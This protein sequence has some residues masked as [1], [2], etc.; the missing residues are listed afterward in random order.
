EKNIWVNLILFFFQAEDGIRDFHVTGVQTCA[1]PILFQKD[2]LKAIAKKYD[3]EVE[4]LHKLKKKWENT[5]LKNRAQR[6]KPL[7][8]DKIIISW[9][10]QLLSGFLSAYKI[11]PTKELN[12]AIENLTSFLQYKALKNDNLGHVFKND[13]IYIDGKDR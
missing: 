12:Q 11:I 7:L 13:A 3:L 8:D 5:L 4:N 6:K 10:A 1:L 2:D 9:N